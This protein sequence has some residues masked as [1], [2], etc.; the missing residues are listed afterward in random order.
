MANEV[1][2]IKQRLDIVDIVKEYVQLKSAG[3]NHK[4][5]CPFHQEKSG[6][7][8]VSASK[9]I[10]HCFGCH[11]GG[12]LISFIQEIEGIDFYEA[13]KLLGD[14]AGVKIEKKSGKSS[15]KKDQVLDVLAFATKLY[16]K[17]LTTHPKAEEARVYIKQRDLQQ[18]TIDVFQ[19]G[20][21]PD[22]W[23]VLL[24][25]LKQKGFSEQVIKES[26]LM[27]E[28]RER[29][30]IYDR[31]RGRFMIPLRDVYGNVVGF[32]ARAIQ[33]EYTG[34]KYIN[35]PQ[36][37]VYDKSRVVF[38]L[39]FAKQAIKEAGE[40]VIVEGNMDVI[41]S[42]QAGVKQVVAVSGTALTE[43]QLAMLKRFTQKLVMAFDEDAAGI[44]AMKRSLPLA[45]Q[46]GFEIKILSLPEGKDPDECIKQGV[47]LWKSAIA[48][49][50][51]LVDAVLHRSLKQ[52][53]ATTPQGKKQVADDVLVFI[54]AIPSAVVRDHYIKLLTRELQV[55][56]T[57]LKEEMQKK[58]VL[59]VE[60][61]PE[62]KKVVSTK[63]PEELKAT[64][65]YVALL[66]KLPLLIQKYLLEP[67]AL[68]GEDLQNLYKTLR[69]AYDEGNT[70][71]SASFDVEAF[72]QTISN[73]QKDLVSRLDLYRD[74]VFTNLT[75]SQYQDALSARYEFLKRIF[76][77]RQLQRVQTAMKDAEQQKD[78]AAIEALANEFR[79]LTSELSSLGQS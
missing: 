34:G 27:V 79:D 39:S 1:D 23:D 26:G 35:T 31:F 69:N 42:H 58:R 21:A 18:E 16:H 60:Q 76:L 10:W 53:D 14:K 64:R 9:Q 3:T 33:E 51:P 54:K 44:N 73:E 8:M 67:E 41:S 7:F 65:E 66:F 75:D 74:N 5:L 32:T 46:K 48:E 19:L 36:T 28:N 55:S 24:K 59:E 56:E 57:S 61:A 62:K 13:L 38:G 30:S 68:S 12:D 2:E 49:A 70:S 47:D 4:G 40:V 45:L 25:A 20:F 63:V 50:Q 52:Y 11:K 17:I 6:S 43:Q 78:T 15:G 72:L 29:G 22:S 71:E 77:R 37:L